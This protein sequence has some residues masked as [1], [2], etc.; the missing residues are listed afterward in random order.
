MVNTRINPDNGVG[1]GIL[2]VPRGTL[3]DSVC[4]DRTSF[5]HELR[6]GIL[7]GVDP[8]GERD[9]CGDPGE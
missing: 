3:I 8:I 4:H 2:S 6:F 5:L 1:R 9:S 7:T